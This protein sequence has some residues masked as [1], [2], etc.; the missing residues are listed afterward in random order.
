MN[1]NK[2]K[3]LSM[4]SIGLLALAAC[5]NSS[6][7]PEYNDEGNLVVSLGRLTGS[8][9]QLPEG[10][11]YEN[12]AYTRLTEEAL[13]IELR[14]EFEAEGEDYE[15]QLALAISS[16]E[17]PDIM[18]VNSRG[19]LEELYENDLI[20]DLTDV[21][22]EYASDYIK[23]IYE[24]Y[25]NI[26]L[27]DGTFEDRLWGIPATNASTAPQMIWIRQDWLDQLDIQ[28]GSEENN[29]ITIEELELVA[30]EFIDND[31]GES[32]NPIGIPMNYW[33]NSGDY[34]G[35]TFT[36]TSIANIHN[37]YPRYWLEDENGGIT[38]GSLTE[39]TKQS[40]E[41]I[42]EWFDNGILD[43]QFGTRT[44][45]DIMSLA[46]NGET[47]IV[48]GPWHLPDWGLNNVKEMDSEAEFE[49]YILKDDSQNVS[50]VLENP[51]GSYIVA[52]KDFTEP[53]ILIEIVNLFYDDIVNTEDL[54]EEFPEVFNYQEIGVDGSTRPL[55]VEILKATGLIEDYSYI[56][57]AVNEEI[58]VSD[59]PTPSN[60]AI[61]SSIIEYNNNPAEA[62]VSN[63][64]FYHS[65][66]KGVD[67]IEYLTENDMFEWTT[68]VFFGSTSA[69]EQYY[70]NLISLE[71]E[72][73][74]KIVTGIE[75]ID[76]FDVFVEMWHDQGG[77]EI[78]AEIEE[79]LNNRE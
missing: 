57:A 42:A 24:S 22:E 19:E 10:D 6:A 28:I 17:I 41:L 34:G 39:E 14:N 45:D 3:I 70:G 7:E 13:D 48:F 25:D 66:M 44:W 43:P 33:L 51:T 4:T 69:I 55:N 30:E 65:R 71:E 9:P 26:P 78:L 15:R 2:C 35:A 8:N 61:A 74:I 38:N 29:L 67:T 60:R 76:H 72:E 50:V 47:G 11:T 52:S 5:G 12:N 53:E 79:E 68:P 62:D 59:I 75:P 18:L 77:S 63:W 16:G 21:F 46:V 56:K 36:M 58:A 40:I 54:E 20:A 73:F 49:A 37:S 1:I 27:E 23:D 32:G 31:L 64:S